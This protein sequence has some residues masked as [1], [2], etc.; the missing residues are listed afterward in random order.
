MPDGLR[1]GDS[2]FRHGRLFGVAHRWTGDGVSVDL[3][4][5]QRIATALEGLTTDA[6]I[7]TD[8]QFASGEFTWKPREQF[9][10]PFAA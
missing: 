1:C 7:V 10:L 5:G 9:A 2:I 3:A 6:V 8:E 4:N